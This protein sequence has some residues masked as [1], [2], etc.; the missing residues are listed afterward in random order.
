M[1][2]LDIVE[3]NFGIKH[4]LKTLLR[5]ALFM[6]LFSSSP[7]ENFGKFLLLERHNQNSQAV[8]CVMGIHGL[9]NGV[10]SDNNNNN[11]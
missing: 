3:N 4:M 10:F 7:L 9:R 8:F 6:I 5:K 2:V 1:F 11:N